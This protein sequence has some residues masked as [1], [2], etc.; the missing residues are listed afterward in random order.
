MR[1]GWWWCCGRG[2]ISGR[3]MAKKTHPMKQAA[4]AQFDSWADSYARLILNRFLLPGT[5]GMSFCLRCVT[6]LIFMRLED[7]S[8]SRGLLKWPR[9][10]RITFS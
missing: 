7:S 9:L 2:P 4:G 8:M 6:R 1:L 5:I 10:E 3:I